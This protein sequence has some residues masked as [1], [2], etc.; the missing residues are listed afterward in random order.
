MVKNVSLQFV[1][2]DRFRPCNRGLYSNTHRQSLDLAGMLELHINGYEI[3]MTA[4]LYF[5]Y[6]V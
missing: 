3:E 1:A 2:T 6:I 5:L 4:L